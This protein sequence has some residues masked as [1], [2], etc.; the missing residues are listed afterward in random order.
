VRAECR[1]FI[2]QVSGRHVQLVPL[3]FEGLRFHLIAPVLCCSCSGTNLSLLHAF[4]KAS[5]SGRETSHRIS[6]AQRSSIV[7]QGRWVPADM[8]RRVAEWGGGHGKTSGHRGVMHEARFMPACKCPHTFERLRFLSLQTSYQ[9]CTAGEAEHVARTNTLTNEIVIRSETP[10]GASRHV[11]H[12]R[13]QLQWRF[14]TNVKSSSRVPISRAA[15][16]PGCDRA[17]TSY[18]MEAALFLRHAV[19]RSFSVRCVHS[20]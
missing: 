13:P 4:K 19:S 2:Y 15:E 16:P 5:P 18:R 10:K 20:T 6:A 1:I 17:N 3:Q 12:E 11:A 7:Q 8:M 14:R 9:P